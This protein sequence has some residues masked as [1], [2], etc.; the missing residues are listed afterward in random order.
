[1]TYDQHG[2]ICAYGVEAFLA[3]FNKHALKF[4]LDKV[5]SISKILNEGNAKVL[6]FGCGTGEALRALTEYYPNNT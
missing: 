3:P 1:M 5:E 2:D 6:E 4:N